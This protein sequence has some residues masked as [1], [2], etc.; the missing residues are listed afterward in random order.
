MIKDFLKV[1]VISEWFDNMLTVN[2]V[3]LLKQYWII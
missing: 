3:R 2:E 1:T